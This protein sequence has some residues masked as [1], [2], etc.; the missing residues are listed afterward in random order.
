MLSTRHSIA[1]RCQTLAGG[2]RPPE[3]D[4][5][6]MC[7]ASRS[8]ARGRLAPLRGAMGFW[9]RLPGVCAALRPPANFWQGFALLIVAILSTANT[10]AERPITDDDRAHWAFAPVA[11]PAVPDVAAGGLARGP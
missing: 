7:A 8:D 2:R 10:F 9:Q 11:N 1:T 3:R 6:R 4:R 5:P